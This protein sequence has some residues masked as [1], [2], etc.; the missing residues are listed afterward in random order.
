MPTFAIKIC[1]HRQ[2]KEKRIY[3]NLGRKI[4]LLKKTI[5]CVEKNLF[6]FWKYK[7]F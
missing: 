1:Q 5:S 3:E 7:K 6:K 2:R 4:L